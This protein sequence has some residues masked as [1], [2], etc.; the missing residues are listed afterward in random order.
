MILLCLRKYL[1][2]ATISRL[3]VNGEHVGHVLE[4][5]GRPAGVKIKHDTCIPEGVYRVVVNYSPKF[6]RK[7]PLLFNVTPDHSVNRN[8]VRFT[9]IRIHGGN[10]VEHTSGC[11]L[12][13]RHTDGQKSV[14]DNIEPELTAQISAALDAGE[15]VLWVVT[16]DI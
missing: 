7:M 10:T 4:D 3:L 15:E 12:V 14:W 1:Q 16:E 8:G 11:P 2:D 5:V 9:G 6:K 13:A